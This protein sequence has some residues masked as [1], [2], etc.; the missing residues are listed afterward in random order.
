MAKLTG[1]ERK[2]KALEIVKALTDTTIQLYYRWLDESEHE[3]INDYAAPINKALKKHG[4]QVKK[5]TKRPFGFTFEL[6]DG[7]YAVTVTS[8]GYS[9]KLIGKV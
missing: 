9:Y 7:L 8:K 6:G 5:M 2:A 4:V 1:D 3:D